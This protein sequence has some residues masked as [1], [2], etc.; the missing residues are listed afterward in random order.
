V[1]PQVR[2]LPGL[3]EAFASPPHLNQAL[4][5]ILATPPSSARD[6]ELLAE[7]L[8]LIGTLVPHLPPTTYTAIVSSMSRV[9][10]PLMDRDNITPSMAADGIDVNGFNKPSNKY[11]ANISMKESRRFE[12]KATRALR[13]LWGARHCMLKLFFELL[14]CDQATTAT[15]NE[16]MN[17][18][19]F[20]GLKTNVVKVLT[21][22]YLEPIRVES[23]SNRVLVLTARSQG[24]AIAILHLLTDDS[25]CCKHFATAGAMFEQWVPKL[26]N[27]GV[28]G[29]HLVD[30]FQLK[31]GVRAA[32][33]FLKT[34]AANCALSGT[35]GGV[36]S[37]VN[38]LR[39]VR[40]KTAWCAGGDNL[41]WVLR[42]L[43]DRESVTRSCGFGICGDLL[44][45]AWSRPLVLSRGGSDDAVG[46]EDEDEWRSS[47]LEIACRVAADDSEAGIVRSEALAL[48]NNACRIGG[49]AVNNAS[50]DVIEVIPSVGRMLA[51]AAK[52]IASVDSGSSG[53]N[54]TW[55][56]LSEEGEEG[57]GEE[58][59]EALGLPTPTLLCAG[60]GLLRTL[61]LGV[62]KRSREAGDGN[63]SD[64]ELDSSNESSVLMEGE[65]ATHFYESGV[66]S[67]AISLLSSDGVRD[68]YFK[69]SMA[70]L[71]LDLEGGIVGLGGGLMQE[72][73]DRVEEC[74]SLVTRSLVFDVVNLSVLISDE[75][76]VA[77]GVGVGQSLLRHTPVLSC[78]FRTLTTEA[79]AIVRAEGGGGV[80]G[81]TVLGSCCEL[82]NTF[83]SNSVVVEGG[84][85]VRLNDSVLEVVG[86]VPQAM[87]V[88]FGGLSGLSKVMS[89][90]EVERM[91]TSMFR[92]LRVLLAVP[93]W[94]EGLLAGGL[95]GGL[96][97]LHHERSLKVS[98][99]APHTHTH[100]RTHSVNKLG[101]RNERSV[102]NALFASR[103]RRKTGSER[104]IREREPRRPSR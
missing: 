59:R 97:E 101:V 35:G 1:C 84:R 51:R 94:G 75:G 16:D 29:V 36:L 18:I 96:L 44:H 53:D 38:S 37:G 57:A 54:D 19:Q 12:R 23:G 65:L 13:A 22:F 83:V 102:Q 3:A 43:N 45:L 79:M 86:K 61:L 5:R 25:V 71:R 47:I 34:I 104:A 64:G 98:T 33:P 9:F 74:S 92:L 73:W 66:L 68:M 6:H 30:S 80:E 63:N 10:T 28:T 52:W 67:H 26:I 103:L 11:G 60:V 39:Q 88:A 91:C 4:H 24:S 85:V 7:S 15:Q 31:G 2:L 81:L 50:S 90:E 56:D 62:V 99:R 58:R 95:L 93:S 14:S 49:A 89:G 46:E 40:E 72:V 17:A 48:L 32:A 78:C 82:L 87:G 27:L 20:V 8:Q 77:G 41:D 100:A 55:G 21:D 76:N 70:K 69:G 42:L